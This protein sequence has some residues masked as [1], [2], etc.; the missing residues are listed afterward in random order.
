MAICYWD[1]KILLSARINGASFEGMATI[2]HQSLYLYPSEVKYFQQQYETHFPNSTNHLLKEYKFGDYSDDFLSKLLGV[3]QLTVVDASAYEG[4]DV[5]HDLNQP[6][7]ESFKNKFDVVLDCGT[8]EHIFNFPT[9]VANLMQMTKVGG[10]LFISTPSNNLDGHG[11]FQFSPE[12]MFRIFT[13]ENGFE[14]TRVVVT[15]NVFPSF[16][17]TPHR[18][19]YQVIDPQIVRSRVGLRS[20]GPVM[21]IIEAVKLEDIHPFSKFPIQSDYASL[22]EQG[23]M[24]ARSHSGLKQ[25]LKTIYEM[26][27]SSWNSWIAGMRQKRQ[28]SLSNRKYYKLLD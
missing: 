10:R 12:L 8:L 17:M 4:A 1:A 21:M 20:K 27:P 15:E 18:A 13:K 23:R 16:E 25:I 5:I 24:Q 26:L 22:W 11:F 9:A 6:I 7:P 28:F 14:L 19:A 3:K 2:G